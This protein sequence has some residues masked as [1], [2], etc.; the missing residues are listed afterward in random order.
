MLNWVQSKSCP[1]ACA[2]QG[3]Q[4]VPG[5]PT[6]VHCQ[7]W[8][9]REQCCIALL[10]WICASYG[11][12][13]LHE[14]EKLS[15]SMTAIYPES[16][17]PLLHSKAD[18]VTPAAKYWYSS[19]KNNPHAAA[20]SGTKPLLCRCQG[21]PVGSPL[22]ST[23][24]PLMSPR[25]DVTGPLVEQSAASSGSLPLTAGSPF[26]SDRLPDGLRW[27]TCSSACDRSRVGHMFL[28]MRQATGSETMSAPPGTQSLAGCHQAHRGHK[29]IAQI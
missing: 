9:G 29:A 22:S 18:G 28:N 25:S 13:P 10:V 3:T 6:G 14:P 27:A 12:L 17:A 15:V 16:K 4:L 24:L 21:L 11:G 20:L 7:V 8:H 5:T 26:G 19:S 1:P 2:V 23:C